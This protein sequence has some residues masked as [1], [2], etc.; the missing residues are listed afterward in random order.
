MLELLM[1]YLSVL[2]NWLKSLCTMKMMKT[3]S[4]AFYCGQKCQFGYNMQE[5]EGNVHQIVFLAGRWFTVSKPL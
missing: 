5:L 4:R 2:K 3:G 1:V